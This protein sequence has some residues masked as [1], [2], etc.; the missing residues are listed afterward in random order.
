MNAAN[1]KRDHPLDIN[2]DGSKVPHPSLE[3]AKQGIGPSPFA[4]SSSAVSSTPAPVVSETSSTSELEHSALIVDAEGAIKFLL[5]HPGW[6]IFPG[7]IERD[8][9]RWLKLPA[10]GLRWASAATADPEEVRR[11]WQTYGTLIEGTGGKR[12][13]CIAVHVGRSGLL[14]LDQDKD[15]ATMEGPVPETWRSVL[16]ETNTL[17]LRSCTR[18]MPH[19]VFRQ[20]DGQ[21]VC[22]QDWVAGEVKAQN[23]YV[24]ISSLAPYASAETKVVPES[25]SS[26]LRVVEGPSASVIDPL[27]TVDGSVPIGT[28]GSRV[29]MTDREL[30][31]WL[32][33]TECKLEPSQEDAIIEELVKKL[34]EQAE[35]GHRRDAMRAMC[36]MLAIEASAGLYSAQKAWDRLE[37]AYI[38]LR[39]DPVRNKGVR[40]KEWSSQWWNDA[41]TLLAGAVEKVEN[42]RYDDAIAEKRERFCVWTDSEQ[43]ALDRWLGSAADEFEAETAVTATVL[44]TETA[45]EAPPSGPLEASAETDEPEDAPTTPSA[46]SAPEASLTEPE[47]EPGPEPAQEPVERQQQQ[48]QEEPD[49]PKPDPLADLRKEVEARG[50]DLDLVVKYNQDHPEDQDPIKLSVDFAK[51]VSK[52]RDRRLVR[53]LSSALDTTPVA[54]A[55]WSWLREGG[56]SAIAEKTPGSFLKRVDGEGIIYDR[57]CVHLIGDKSVGKSWLATHLAVERMDNGESIAWL[58]YETDEQQVAERLVQGGAKISQI[59]DQFTYFAM[60]GESIA[61]AVSYIGSLPESVRPTALIVD[62]VDA[63]MASSGADDENSSSGYHAWRA[64]IA[65][66]T[67]M[68]VTVLIEHTGHDN[69]HRARGA[70]AKGQQADQ[71]FSAKV[72]RPFSKASGGLVEWTCRKNRRGG[73]FTTDDVAAYL[74]I[75]PNGPVLDETTGLPS[76]LDNAVKMTLL[77]PGD[78]SVVAAGTAAA[79]TSLIELDA[80]ARMSVRMNSDAWSATALAKKLDETVTTTQ[81]IIDDWVDIGFAEVASGGG[82]GPTKYRVKKATN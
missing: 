20:R 35:S 39:N 29:K 31:V 64:A 60:K 11:L 68:M 55:D 14:V 48:Q 37:E 2:E 43:E 50:V 57:G 12:V 80:K 73:T 26:L 49:T 15:L 30:E 18:Q 38:E 47:S 59:I 22:I 46:E 34:E 79:A 6:H 52:E 25:V 82:S 66:L 21:S 24:F 65:P 17:V 78:P 67:E 74:Q 71:E 42:G 32:A 40:G 16:A 33:N 9:G 36:M 56:L 10:K 4:S 70:S 76:A 7:R 28:T 3:Q 75:D 44:A 51:Q 53:K 13:A 23:G 8:A 19:Y 61:G 81:M 63:S 1:L 72:I 27:D 58:D 45:E 41:R 77:A 54:P 62:S 69:T 5:D